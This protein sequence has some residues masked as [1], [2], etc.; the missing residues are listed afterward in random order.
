VK[1]IRKAILLAA[2]RGTRLGDLTGRTPKP[3][4]EV[5]GAPILAHILEALAQAGIEQAI[6]VAGYLAVQIEEF[7]ARFADSHLLAITTVRQTTL[8]GTGGAILR[9]A[10]LIG[11]GER[12]VFGWGDV[13]MDREY[14]QRFMNEAQRGDYDLLLTINYLDDPYRGAAVYA[15]DQMRVR[16]IVEKPAPGTSTT[17]WNNAGLFASTTRLFDYVARLGPSPRGELEL[18]AAIAAM[19]E[20]G[21][22]VRAVELRGFWS[23]VGTREDLAAARAQFRPR[24]S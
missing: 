22:Q 12:F 2:G 13:L 18:T 4:L 9:A 5:G 24:S 10:P 7:C 6:V 17:N 14:Y 11:A 20:D 19:V 16:R 15:N 1:A 8:N 21:A 23:D 3:L